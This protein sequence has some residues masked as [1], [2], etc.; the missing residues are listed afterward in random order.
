MLTRPERKAVLKRL[1]YLRGQLEGIE[2]MIEKERPIK[3]VSNQLKAVEQAL[4]TTIH[5][6]LEDQLKMHLAELLSERLAACPGNCSDAQRLQFT[7]QQ[8]ASLDLKEIIQSIEWL[9]DKEGGGSESRSVKRG[10]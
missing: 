2:K 4:Q 9:G 5:V 8:F 10:R 1:H 6:V 7:K 3:E